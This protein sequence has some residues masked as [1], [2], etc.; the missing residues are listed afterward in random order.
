MQQHHP[1]LLQPL[2]HL[3]PSEPPTQLVKAVMQATH[4]PDPPPQYG[5]VTLG[6][7]NPS[8]VGAGVFSIEAGTGALLVDG[9]KMCG[10]YGGTESAWVYSCNTP[11]RTN[12]APITCDQGQTGGGAL[13]CSA[14]IMN[15]IEDF[16]DENDPVCYATGGAWTQFMGYQFL[17]TYYLLSI[18]SEAAATGSY[19]PISLIIQA[20]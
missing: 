8:G 16:N 10:F 6:E 1:L 12:E 5:S 4:Q 15:C 17:S 11:P 13:K 9:S 3:Q 7:Y 18:G 14:A 2:P 20:L 19:V